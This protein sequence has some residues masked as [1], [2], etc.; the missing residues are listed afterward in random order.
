MDSLCS[1]IKIW[2]WTTEER[3]VLFNWKI[4][5]IKQKINDSQCSTFDPIGMTANESWEQL[6]ECDHTHRELNKLLRDYNNELWA[7]QKE[8]KVYSFF[9]KFLNCPKD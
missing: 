7:I 1:K 4:D 8:S 3:E 9:D 2:I 6:R 5:R